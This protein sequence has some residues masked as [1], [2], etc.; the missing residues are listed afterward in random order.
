[1]EWIRAF[2]FFLIPLRPW[3]YERIR[4]IRNR[5]FSILVHQSSSTG[6]RPPSP[7]PSP[8]PRFT[9]HS[10]QCLH[11]KSWLNS[12]ETLCPLLTNHTWKPI[13]LHLHIFLSA[14]I[15]LQI[16]YPY[17]CTTFIATPIPLC[18]RQEVSSRTG[19]EAK[20]WEEWLTWTDWSD[21]GRAGILFFLSR[22]VNAN[23]VWL[24]IP[25]DN[26]GQLSVW[27]VKF[28]SY[29]AVWKWNTYFHSAFWNMK[30]CLT[31]AFG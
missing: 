2:Y 30:C 3:S 24:Y 21:H 5:P 17:G 16:F 8:P 12:D 11:L 13:P 25:A 23:P 10:D 9:S 1:M 19:R 7:P 26:E 22:F 18:M 29:D 28:T 20:G 14:V 27:D 15:L 31:G 6:V 4:N